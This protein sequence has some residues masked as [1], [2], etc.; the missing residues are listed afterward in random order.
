MLR[1]LLSLSA[2]GC[3][4]A[5]LGLSV[6]ESRSWEEMLPTR[7]GVLLHTRIVMPRD[8]DGSGHTTIIDRSPYGYTD[9][10]WIPDLF[11]PGGFA[12][13]G[14]D[15]RGTKESEGRFSIWHSDA[16]DSE[17]LGNWIVQQPWSNGRVYSLGASAD[18][19][20][21]FTTVHNSPSWLGAQYFI[22]TSSIGY[23]VFYPGGAILNELVD[24]W[25]HGT[26]D[27]PEN[28]ADVCYEDIK[29]NEMHSEW[30]S[31]VE[32]T[33]MYDKVKFPSA[34]WAGW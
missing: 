16:N 29:K 20:A 26:V 12:T 11:L 32:L 23:D 5:R 7:D 6:N 30:W 22:W 15:M 31:A 27:F 3:A 17:D 33:G 2:I 25:I 10:E 18:G 14:Q 9:L 1:I 8:D 19:L 4:V 34:F 24:S 28:W 21:A 13:V